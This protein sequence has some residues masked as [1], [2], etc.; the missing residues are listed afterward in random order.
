MVG[1]VEGTTGQAYPWNEESSKAD[2]RL[3]FVARARDIAARTPQPALLMV[4][5]EL[6]FPVL[7]TDAADL[8]DALRE[9][10]TQPDHVR[11][12][13]VAGLPHP[14]AEQ[15][16]LE[17]PAPQLSTAKAVDE[18]LTEWFLRHLTTR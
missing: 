6:D 18:E 14:L 13:T 9:P 4:S 3:D 16:G 1:L 11:L 5:G 12:T 2:D 7:R 8:V 17:P 15:P 10:Y